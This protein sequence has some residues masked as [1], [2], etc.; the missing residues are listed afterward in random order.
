MVD[1]WD[2]TLALTEMLSMMTMLTAEL[3]RLRQEMESTVGRTERQKDSLQ[4]KLATMDND[5]QVALQQAKHS[6]D[7]DVKRLT[8]IKASCKEFPNFGP[9]TELSAEKSGFQQ[10]PKLV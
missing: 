4:Q 9:A 10:I 7:D 8:E 3:Q 2:T 1:S 6:H 5:H